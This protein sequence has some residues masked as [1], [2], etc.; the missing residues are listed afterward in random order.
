M[1][2][3]NN[4]KSRS[5]ATYKPRNSNTLAIVKSYL[6][7]TL[8]RKVFSVSV[9]GTAITTAGLVIPIT[10]GIV[11]GD[12]IANRQGTVINLQR[13]R[14][15][16]RAQGTASCSV[17]YILFRDMLNQG[18]TPNVGT[19]L[20]TGTWISQY[21]DTRQIQQHRFKIIKDVT[22][23][24]NVA[25]RN[26][27]TRQFDLAMKGKTIYNGATAVPGSD[28]PGAI[29]LLVIGSSASGSYDYTVQVRFS[30]A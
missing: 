15:L 11:E 24:L 23:D 27:V 18:V 29:Y 4:N 28:G 7:S 17:R 5:N 26:T 21:A 10:N 20:P 9:V 6:D 25:G 22:F 14:M 19:L 16:L 2:R 1:T 8:E 13:I 30:D 12:D 3:A